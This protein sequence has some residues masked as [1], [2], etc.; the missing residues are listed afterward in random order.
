M[1]DPTGRAKLE[2][3]YRRLL[4]AYPRSYRRRNAAEMVTTLLD[5]APAGRTRPSLSE[6]VDLLLAGVRY[7]L[8]VR[9]PGAVF[10][11]AC[12]AACTA[13]A[14][15]ALGGFLGWQTAPP[16][17]SDV[18]AAHVA[19]PALRA[20]SPVPPQRWDFVFDDNPNY[21]DPRWAYW[22]GGTDAYE[23]GQVFFDLAY[24]SDTPDQAIADDVE[25][26][27][28]R[29]RAA[30]WR[31]TAATK[32]PV[33]GGQPAAYRRGWRVEI[34][35]TSA[36]LGDSTQVM[37]VAVTRDAPAAVLP[38]TTVGLVVG[39]L[40]GWLLMAWTC[41]RGRAIGPWRRVV[42]VVGFACGVIALLPA[43]VMS[44]IAIASSYLFPHDLVPAW[45]GYTFVFFRA[46]AWLAA[47]A[48]AGAQLVTAVPS[49]R[50]LRPIAG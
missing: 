46:L 12:G 18:D 4:L 7:R 34:Y 3:R 11:A 37:R 40:V 30:G 15:A 28:Q 1:P 14:V 23:H 6:A 32:N 39:G 22:L 33:T 29:M 21:L 42:A 49:Q 5:A 38:L 41:R 9:G 27:R 17:P 26:A 48:F 35:P 47:I 43:T 16:L 20:G 44:A 13:V 24:P 2:R 25:R 10:A 50:H 19:Q 45:A 36:G 8:R 31:L